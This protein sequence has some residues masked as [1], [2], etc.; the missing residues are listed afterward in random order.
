MVSMR[1]VGLDVHAKGTN[2]SVLD[3]ETGEI[4]YRRIR[5]VPEGPVL[6]W[7]ASLRND[8]LHWPHRDRVDFGDRR[9]GWSLLARAPVV[10]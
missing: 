6:D 7:L 2:G 1:S 9:N 4:A 10:A 3:P 8:N 5:G